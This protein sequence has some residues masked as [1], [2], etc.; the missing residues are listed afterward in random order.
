M[1]CLQL[2]MPVVEEKYVTEVAR[3]QGE[4]AQREAEVVARDASI[5]S[6]EDQLSGLGIA[7]ITRA[8]SSGHGRTSP[9]SSAS[10]LPQ[11]WFFE[12][13]PDS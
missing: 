6:L 13:P 3:L 5:R 9:P 8:S 12:D 11:D 1:L 7:P 2:E 4:L 10:P